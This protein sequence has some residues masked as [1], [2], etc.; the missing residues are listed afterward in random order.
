MDCLAVDRANEITKIQDDPEPPEAVLKTLPVR[1]ACADLT[2]VAAC[3][4]DIAEL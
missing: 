2:V 4:N 3:F 1:R